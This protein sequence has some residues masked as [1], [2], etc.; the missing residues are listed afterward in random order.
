[1]AFIPTLK[2]CTIS[3]TRRVTAI[4]DP[5][6]GVKLST[7]SGSEPNLK[8][9][10]DGLWFMEFS[11]HYSFKENVTVADLGGNTFKT[12]TSFIIQNVKTFKNHSNFNW[13]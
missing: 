4:E 1:M 7:L 13:G 2:S 8:L 5:L 9:S 12:T 11:N 6:A 3:L 10:S